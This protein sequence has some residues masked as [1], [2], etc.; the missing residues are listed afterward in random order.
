MAL[1]ATGVRVRAELLLVVI[2][3]QK[4]KSLKKGICG[5]EQ[6]TKILE[7]TLRQVLPMLPLPGEVRR[8]LAFYLVSFLF[9]LPEL[10]YFPFF[11]FF[12]RDRIG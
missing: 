12:L 3:P 8:K 7:R 11:F 6:L 10:T 1:L 4:K 2:N 9:C 5:F